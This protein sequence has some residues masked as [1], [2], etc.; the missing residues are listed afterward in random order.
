MSR[1]I[2]SRPRASIV[3]KDSRHFY[4]VRIFDFYNYGQ[5]LTLKVDR[6]ASHRLG[7]SMV[8]EGLQHA[9]NASSELSR[10]PI[11]YAEHHYA[12]LKA[13]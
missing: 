10:G 8:E 13:G 1:P 4:V 3:V 9:Y 11:S 12:T 6:Q 2:K 7:I 5:L